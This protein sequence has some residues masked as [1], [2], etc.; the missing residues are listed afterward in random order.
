MSDNMDQ[1]TNQQVKPTGLSYPIHHYQKTKGT[2]G[3]EPSQM[4]NKLEYHM[5]EYIEN[6]KFRFHSE[7]RHNSTCNA[8]EQKHFPLQHEQQ[9]KLHQP[10]HSEH[11]VTIHC[12][13]GLIPKQTYYL[14][15]HHPT[16][17]HL[18]S[19]QN[20]QKQSGNT[21]HINLKDRLYELMPHKLIK[22]IIKAKGVH[23]LD[24]IGFEEKNH[25]IQSTQFS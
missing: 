23:R 22:L 17:T 5:K 16:L 3:K 7:K 10:T 4:P 13:Q 21:I 8:Q 11:V 15:C 19:K 9:S 2:G 12:P 14:D 24:W 6:F 1:A 18:V 20:S 25:P